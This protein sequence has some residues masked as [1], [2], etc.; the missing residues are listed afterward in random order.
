MSLRD[1]SQLAQLLTARSSIAGGSDSI[2]DKAQ[3]LSVL[4]RAL[5]APDIE[6]SRRTIGS[7]LKGVIGGAF[8]YG[9]AKGIGSEMGLSDSATE[10]V[11]DAGPHIII[12]LAYCIIL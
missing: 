2:L 1:A 5:Q 7:I 12:D 9:L 10:R 8:G 3:N 4:D 11:A 6:D